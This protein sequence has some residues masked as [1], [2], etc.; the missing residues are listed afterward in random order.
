MLQEL[1]LAIAKSTRSGELTR[2]V[3]EEKELNNAML[4]QAPTWWLAFAA[5]DN[6]VVLPKST[7][8]VRPTIQ[9][10]LWFAPP[11]PCATAA[12]LRPPERKELPA[13]RWTTT[14]EQ[15]FASCNFIYGYPA[16]EEELRA[17]PHPPALRTACLQHVVTIG[18]ESDEL[19]VGAARFS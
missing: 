3:T 5:F 13:P 18:A 12:G 11:I 7:S 16:I 2:L 9:P 6:L 14:D 19:F 17:L 8:N 10:F 1:G 15:Q 4:E